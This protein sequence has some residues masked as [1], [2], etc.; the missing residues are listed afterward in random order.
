MN[1][2]NFSKVTHV[3]IQS[4]KFL[5]T[6]QFFIDLQHSHEFMMLQFQKNLTNAT[7]FSQQKKTHIIN[8]LR[9]NKIKSNPKSDKKNFKEEKI[10]NLL[11]KKWSETECENSKYFH[12]HLIAFYNETKIEKK[13]TNKIVVENSNQNVALA[14]FC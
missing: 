11:N 8:L 7:I 12:V 1:F 9:K 5:N 13:T 14:Q 4:I 6:Q 2:H 3:K 10:V